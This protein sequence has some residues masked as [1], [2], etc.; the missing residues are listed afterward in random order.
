MTSIV[1]AVLLGG[2]VAFV[3]VATGCAA[4]PRAQDDAPASAD[5]TAMLASWMTGSFSSFDQS[6]EDPDNYLDI[7][8]HMAPI[9][10]DAEGIWLYVEQ[11][12]GAAPDRPYRQRVYK[13]ERTTDERGE[14][15]VS[16]VF[17]LPDPRAAVGAWRQ[18]ERVAGVTPADLMERDGCAV[19]LRFIDD[20]SD[21]RFVGS[22]RGRDCSSSLRGA[23]YATSIVTVRDG[24]VES[25]DRGFDDEGEQVWGA[26][27]GAY[28]FVRAN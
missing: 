18:P 4:G 5:R 24:N 26:T 22:T 12:V 13:V 8:L 2:F 9:W 19:E 14:L 27:E 6:Q 3:G 7:S 21:P 15:Y 28:R 1:R 16:R 10:P 17:E 11:A 20:G 23:A 25:W